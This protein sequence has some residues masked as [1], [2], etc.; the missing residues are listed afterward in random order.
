MLAMDIDKTV[1]DLTEKI[2]SVQ[3]NSDAS[4]SV[5]KRIEVSVSSAVVLVQ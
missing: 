3:D 5:I 2:A 1:K 4:W